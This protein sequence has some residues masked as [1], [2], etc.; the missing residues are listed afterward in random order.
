MNEIKV[1]D[2]TVRATNARDEVMD[3]LE[4]DK[5]NEEI[6]KSKRKENEVLHKQTLEYKS[7]MHAKVREFAV[8]QKV[9]NT[10]RNPFNTKINEMSMATAKKYEKDLK[11]K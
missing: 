2:E 6:L 9:T 11:K 5:Q 1:K 8:Q 4:Y 3:K 7:E 10:K